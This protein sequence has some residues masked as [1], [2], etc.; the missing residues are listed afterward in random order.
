MTDIFYTK[1]H[2]WIKLDGNSGTIGITAY[3]AKQLGD[4]TYI[5]LPETETEL[6]QGESLCEIESVKAA[7]DIYAPISGSITEVNLS[8][9]S[10]PGIINSSPKEK[11]WIAKIE[12]T[13]PDEVSS[14][15]S[16]YQYEEYIKSL[17]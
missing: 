12:T 4:I 9:D 7:S 15:L 2:E 16:D 1:N 13:S 17:G 14:L 3:A 8:L 11:G 10:S 5:D 6:Q